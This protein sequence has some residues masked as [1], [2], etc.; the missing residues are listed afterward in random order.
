MTRI[1]GQEPDARNMKFQY[2][3]GGI[4][5]ADRGKLFENFN[6]DPGCRIFLSTK[7]DFPWRKN[8]ISNYQS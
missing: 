7:R 6:N 2:L 4:P 5:G 3:H 1:V 8:N